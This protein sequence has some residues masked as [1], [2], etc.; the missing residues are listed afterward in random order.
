MLIPISVIC[1]KLIQATTPILHTI[2]YCI[3]RDQSLSY[4]I[5]SSCAIDDDAHARTLAFRYDIHWAISVCSLRTKDVDLQG[6]RVY[7]YLSY[8]PILEWERLRLPWTI[9]RRGV[10]VYVKTLISH[11]VCRCSGTGGLQWLVLQCCFPLTL[12]YYLLPINK[13]SRMYR[14]RWEPQI[15]QSL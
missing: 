1:A 12:Q 13:I 9:M 7:E 2:W 14:L 5:I 8:D 11:H 10:I 15:P 4:L 3:L 6:S